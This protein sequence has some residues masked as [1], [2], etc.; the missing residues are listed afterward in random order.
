MIFFQI[1][2]S[3]FTDGSI[4]VQAPMYFSVK[5][6][7]SFL[8]PR[9]AAGSLPREMVMA[10]YPSFSCWNPLLLLWHCR[11]HAAVGQSQVSSSLYLHFLPPCL[12]LS[13]HY[14]VSFSPRIFWFL[15]TGPRYVGKWPQIRSLGLGYWV[16]T[17]SMTS[18]SDSLS[19]GS[20]LRA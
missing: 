11:L 18:G 3:R 20:F 6:S 15:E 8:T 2:F 7:S 16:P 10:V 1:F 9:H 12:L 13:S 19:L 17:M 5:N 14:P 4:H